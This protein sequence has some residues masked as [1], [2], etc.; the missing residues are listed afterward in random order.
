MISIPSVCRLLRPRPTFQPHLLNALLHALLPL[1]KLD[2][3][4]SQACACWGTS[5][6]SLLWR[7]T[8]HEPSIKS[9]SCQIRALLHTEWETYPLRTLVFSMGERKGTHI[10]LRDILTIKLKEELL[11]V[12]MVRNKTWFLFLWNYLEIPPR[13]Y[14]GN[15]I[16][17]LTLISFSS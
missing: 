12:P 16:W 8:K 17:L 6:P 4:C 1:V 14:C 10:N 5:V 7:D 2:C 15:L 9:P 11:T 13:S 3:H